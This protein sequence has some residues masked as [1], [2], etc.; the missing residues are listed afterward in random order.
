M[1]SFLSTPVYHAHQQ[2]QSKGLSFLSR[3]ECLEITAALFGYEHYRLMKPMLRN[4]EAA[5]RQP[6]AAVIFAEWS[7]TRRAAHLLAVNGAP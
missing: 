1:S 6:G 3:S 5:L 4:L 7:A 2:A